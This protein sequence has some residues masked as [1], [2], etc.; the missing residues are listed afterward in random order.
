MKRN[1]LFTVLAASVVISAVTVS[2]LAGS[3]SGT[4]P[5]N[6][7]K[8]VSINNPPNS[9][10]ISYDIGTIL[11]Y[12]DARIYGSASSSAGHYVKIYGKFTN[13]SDVL[14]MSQANASSPVSVNGSVELDAVDE[15]TGSGYAEARNGT[16]SGGSIAE[17]VSLTITN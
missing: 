14:D 7:K 15:A 12:D 9:V 6:T 3:T 10:S 5:K 8:T 4:T 11:P 16:S 2:A 13:Y 1:K 17:R